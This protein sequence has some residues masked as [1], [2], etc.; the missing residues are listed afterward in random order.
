MGNAA[1][2][3]IISVLKAC[4]RFS[5][6]SWDSTAWPALKWRMM[7]ASGLQTIIVSH[8]G[9]KII[10]NSEPIRKDANSYK[11]PA[12][13][14]IS[15]AFMWIW[16]K[17]IAK[18][19]RRTWIYKLAFNSDWLLADLIS[20]NTNVRLWTTRTSWKSQWIAKMHPQRYFAFILRSLSKCACS[21]MALANP[22]IFWRHNASRNSTR[23]HA[24]GWK[25]P[26]S[27]VGTTIS[28]ARVS[29]SAQCFAMTR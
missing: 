1:P 13:G 29:I 5:V 25:P 22:S 6:L 26:G 12:N 9:S 11:R 4:P 15:H 28:S 8:F 19:F 17:P 7:P 2:L 16:S 18:I 24:S 21:L 23:T 3:K 10:A 14:R 20:S 27:I